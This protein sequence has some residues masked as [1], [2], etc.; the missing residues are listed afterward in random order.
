MYL[1]RRADLPCGV[2]AVSVGSTWA[3]QANQCHRGRQKEMLKQSKAAE[4]DPKVWCP[5]TVSL[6]EEAARALADCGSQC[7]PVQTRVAHLDRDIL[8]LFSLA[9]P[10]SVSA[11]VRTHNSLVLQTFGH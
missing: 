10:R 8:Q 6:L 1:A 5:Y 9:R 2:E 3:H 7:L 4:I 11:N